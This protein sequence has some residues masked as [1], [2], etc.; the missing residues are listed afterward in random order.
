[1]YE[2]GAFISGDFRN[3]AT[4]RDI[5]TDRQTEREVWVLDGVKRGRRRLSAA[6][7][8]N[9]ATGPL[10]PLQPPDPCQSCW[11]QFV[12][13]RWRRWSGR[14]G[15]RMQP[16]A[17]ALPGSAG[18]PY[19]PDG[20]QLC[21]TIVTFWQWENERAGRGASSWEHLSGSVLGWRQK[22]FS[23]LVVVVV[24]IIRN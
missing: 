9:A 6:D 20:R 18:A 10:F 15:Q 14:R 11:R 17:P 13:D 23:F 7:H 16:E 2:T 8:W 22:I 19:R 5:Q 12:S 4:V 24:V 1:M 21:V 3:R